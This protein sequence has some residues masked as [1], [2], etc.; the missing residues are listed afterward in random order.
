M[1]CLKVITLLCVF[2]SLSKI[3]AA[4]NDEFWNE[5]PPIYSCEVGSSLKQYLPLDSNHPHKLSQKLP[6]RNTFHIL[7]LENLSRVWNARR[8]LYNR[9]GSLPLV[10]AFD[11][12]LKKLLI[13]KQRAEQSYPD[14]EI[15]IRVWQLSTEHIIPIFQEGL[16]PDIVE[17]FMLKIT[18][19][20][21]SLET[22]I[23]DVHILYLQYLSKF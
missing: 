4:D 16:E 13:T 11:K 5:K 14:S 18:S 1:R 20:D 3:S 8:H 23:N 21:T 10:T 19:L 9:I 2:S 12:D 22:Y 7:P 6:N 15:A 17:G